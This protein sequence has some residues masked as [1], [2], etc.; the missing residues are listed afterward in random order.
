MMEQINGASDAS[1]DEGGATAVE[2]SHCI[3]SYYQTKYHSGRYN[4]IRCKTEKLNS[5]H[6]LRALGESDEN[7]EPI[8]QN[9]CSR[10]I[11]GN[12]S[13]LKKFWVFSNLSMMTGIFESLNQL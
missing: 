8:I 1:D 13:F 4:K 6:F 7:Q 2:A 5:K 11:K 12:T 9:R 10:A 3:G